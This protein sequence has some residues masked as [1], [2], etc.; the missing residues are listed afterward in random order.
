MKDGDYIY[1]VISGASINNDGSSKAGYMAPSEE[2]QI[3]CIMDAYHKSGIQ[4][5]SVCYVETH[6]T[7]TRIGDAIEAS[8]L[9]QAFSSYTNKKSYCVLGS[10][11][12]NIGHTDRA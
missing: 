1:G 5:E 11:K 10:V 2:G 12:G 8:A 9:I 4:P 7:G 3:K 6:G